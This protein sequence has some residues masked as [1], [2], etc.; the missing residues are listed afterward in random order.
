MQNKFKCFSVLVLL[1]IVV[2]NASVAQEL[3]GASRDAVI[4]KITVATKAV[5]SLHNSFVQTKQSKM[6]KNP[7]VS[8][9]VMTYKSPNYLRWEYTKP[10]KVVVSVNGN[11]VQ[12]T[13]N[14]VKSDGS[15]NRMVSE[16]TS[17]IMGCVSGAHIFDESSFVVSV[18][19][20][21]DAYQVQLVPR[22]RKMK[23]MFQS[24]TISFDK[25]SFEVSSVVLAEKSDVS[26]TIRFTP[27]VEKAS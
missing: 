8:E 24:I 25:K 23:R 22:S 1:T 13:R 3:N 20:L 19:E 5:K 6:L 9:G 18:F 2:M 10:E 17:T 27:I 16:L 21:S 4:E 12:M 15:A 14:G 26:T 11:A 7:V